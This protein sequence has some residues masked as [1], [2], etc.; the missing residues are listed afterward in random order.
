[1]FFTTTLLI[2]ILSG[3]FSS[4]VGGGAGLVAVPLLI[5]IGLPVY[6]AV[7]TPK[8]GAL[9][10]AFGSLAKF[11]KTD[12]ILWKYIPAL[13][14]IAVVAGIVGANLLL[15]VPEYFVKNIVVVLFILTA[16][17]LYSK[18]SLGIISTT[19]SRLKHFFGYIFYF[20]A[21]TFRAAFGSGFGT[22]TG[23]VLMYFFGFTMLESNAT[24]K[25]AGFVVSLIAVIVFASKGILDYTAG[26]GLFIGTIFGSYIGTH[27]AIMA[28]DK[29]LK[30]IF[31]VFAV[32]MSILILL[33][34]Q[35]PLS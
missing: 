7:S 17:T 15:T 19:T 12:L 35:I 27:Y 29:W 32:V 2:G 22:L 11:S 6:S 3:A 14:G 28:G 23:V 21:E 9:G 31:T 1:M 10:I 26:V 24:K 20:L 30:L 16:I 33:G 4:F 34:V 18:K 8:M 5:L 13:L 25:I